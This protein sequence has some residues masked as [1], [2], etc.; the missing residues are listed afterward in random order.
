MLHR[1]LIGAAA[2]SFTVVIGISV[3]AQAPASA[4]ASSAQAPATRAP[5]TSTRST[6]PQPVSPEVAAAQ[7]DT[8]VKACGRCHPPEYVTQ[9]RRSKEQWEESINTMVSSRGAVLTPEEYTTV[10]AYL[11]RE[12]GPQPASGSR[13]GGTPTSTI[14]VTPGGTRAPTAANTTP[15][16]GT[17]PGA[18]ARAQPAPR[19]GAGAPATVSATP[20]P[21]QAARPRGGAGP[22]DKH[23]VDAAAAMRGRKTYASACIQC[24]GTQARGGQ[25][26]SNILRSSTLLHDRYGNVL[27]PFLRKGHPVQSGP[28]S[29]TYTDAQMAD[30]SHFLRERFNDT[31]RGSP[32]FTVQNVLTGDV[33]AGEAYFNGDGGCRECHSPTADLKGIGARLDPPALQQRF[34]FPRPPTRG[35]RG[36]AGPGGAPVGKP[37]TVTVTA[38]SGETVTG[39]L[40]SLDDFTV[41]LRDPNGVYR[42]WKRT[43]DLAVV[44]HDPY[45]AHIALLDKYTDKNM[46]D[47]VAYLE[48]LK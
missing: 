33:K 1:A 19:G 40:V 24:H 4:Q 37:T 34:L 2:A 18:T 22:D 45:A 32:V 8:F 26:G 20:A 5:A 17:A 39:V 7:R 23:I 3:W 6:R 21:A 29:S 36:P 42:S 35:P 44:K 27:G 13:R 11:V 41:A 12:W 48:S 9:N 31:L 38:A 28:A 46:H 15:P 25:G 10:L 47:I 14:A 30:L 16:A 43:S